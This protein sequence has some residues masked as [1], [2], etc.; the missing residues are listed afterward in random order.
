M[1][2]KALF[3]ALIAIDVLL[4]VLQIEGLSIGYNEAKILYGDPSPLQFL[5]R[6]SLEL[7]GQNDYA[8]R[9]P[10]I[11]LH[12]V[13]ILFLYRLSGHFVKNESDRLWIS[14]IYVLLPGITSAALIVDDAGLMI[15]AVFLFAYL[16]RRFGRYSL[17]LLPGLL[18]I[19]P[20]FAY[21][22]CAVG[23]YGVLRRDW[24]Y[25]LSG[26]S[27][28]GVSLLLGGIRVEGIPKGHFLDL[29]GVYTAIFSPV[30]FVYLFYILYRRFIAREWDLLWMIAATAFL[31]SLIL[32]FRQ[33]IDIQTI[34]PFMMLLLPLAAENFLRTYRVRLP[35]F[36][37]WYR[38]LFFG[39]LA[40]LAINT[41]VV[42]FNQW[43][44]RFLPSPSK[45][46][47]YPMHVAK[48]LS[49]ALHD[50]N[51]SCIQTEDEHLQLRLYFY[52]ITQCDSYR[53]QN[54]ATREGTK[55]TIR[56]KDVPVSIFY[57]T[58]ISKE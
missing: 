43:L 28:L 22:F 13:S 54:I 39:A 57:V 34:A 31:I 9:L 44:Y 5:I 50:Q 26:W 42:F 29:M 52:G 23:I 7:F 51:I 19:N 47:A 37:R 30:V 8:L 6:L 41:V 55:V 53:L 2:H 48:E 16:H 12:V 35:E 15:T 17:V 3:V 45:H 11:I 24:V 27:M 40:L 14:L 56:Y 1:K 10:M 25:V 46:F 18:A 33:K 49:Y 32:S 4:L 38:V 21:L 58:K 36:R 20:A